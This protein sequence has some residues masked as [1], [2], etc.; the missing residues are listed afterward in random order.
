MSTLTTATLD[1]PRSAAQTTRQ[2]LEWAACPSSFPPSGSL[3]AISELPRNAA[4]AHAL[5]NLT[6][7]TSARIGAGWPAFGDESAI[8]PGAL[9]L[10]AAIGGRI[11]PELATRLAALVPPPALGR[12]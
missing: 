6:R 5:Q 11:Q 12:A 1:W 9:F 4:A 8:G 3:N 2:V 7:A 10:A